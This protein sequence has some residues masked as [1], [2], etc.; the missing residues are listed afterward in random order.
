MT[1]VNAREARMRLSDLLS[2]AEHGQTV[3]ITRHGRV[4]AQLVPPPADPPQPF[5]DLSAFRKSIRLSPNAPSSVELIRQDR[6][7]R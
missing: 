4:V 1:T 2:E 3:S 7:E 6:G 5:P